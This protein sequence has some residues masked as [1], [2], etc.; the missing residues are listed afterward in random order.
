MFIDAYMMDNSTFERV[1][2][3]KHLGITLTNQNAIQAE[4]KSRLR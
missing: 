2:D 1:E 4:I 3:F